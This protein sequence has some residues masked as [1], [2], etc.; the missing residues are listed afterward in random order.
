MSNLSDNEL[1]R[2]SREAAENFEPAGNVQ[3]WN[4]LEQLLDKNL[5]KPAPVPRTIRPGTV[6]LYS[7]AILV[8]VSLTYF[9]IKTNK[10]NHNSTLTPSIT[11]QQPS[12]GNESKSAA[13]TGSVPEQKHTQSG[14]IADSAATVIAETNKSQIA[15]APSTPA[16]PGA[17]ATKKLASDSKTVVLKNKKDNGEINVVRNLHAGKPTGVNEREN[18][19]RKTQNDRPGT[20]AVQSNRQ[21]AGSAFKEIKNNRAGTGKQY[22]NHQ[23]NLIAATG[24]NDSE[25]DQA[26][27]N[28]P[29]PPGYPASAGRQH[30]NHAGNRKNR[31]SDEGLTTQKYSQSNPTADVRQ[32]DYLKYASL[33]GMGFLQQPP[34][35]E[36]NDSLLKS[37]DPK[38]ST[39]NII[40]PPNHRTAF[41]NQSLEIGLVFGPE[42]SKVK[43]LYNNNRVGNGFGLT[44]NYQLL[45]SLSVNSGIIF[46]KKYYQADQNDF[47]APRNVPDSDANIKFVEGSTNVIDIPINLRFNY[48]TDGKSKFFVNGGFSSYIIQSESLNYYCQFNNNVTA[49]QSQRWVRPAPS[50]SPKK[51]YLFSIV[52]FSAGFETSIDKNFSFQFEPYMKLP[53]KGIGI[54]KVDLSSYG[55]SLSLKYTP[56]LHRGRR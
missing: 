4:K 7:G 38:S 34:G 27:Q 10:N 13:G 15:D 33:P 23:G 49:I 41:V 40:R 30:D 50:P 56:I 1:D 37:F 3:S 11:N 39:A 18:E 28:N 47:H 53:V 22:K 24:T 29:N 19:T 36:V 44:F 25:N 54:G 31:S 5:G 9:L 21:P 17:P 32:D 14:A 51:N 45:G 26:G 48:F 43:Y 8:A 42:F 2:L 46:S 55:I 12:R 6:L 20:A 35:T 52:N 16:N